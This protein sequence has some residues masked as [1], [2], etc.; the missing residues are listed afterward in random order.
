[1]RRNTSRGECSTSGWVECWRSENVRDE[2]SVRGNWF[3]LWVE[4][5]LPTGGNASFT[6]ELAVELIVWSFHL[7]KLLLLL[8]LL[9]L[10]QSSRQCQANWRFGAKASLAFFRFCSPFRLFFP[11]R[12]CLIITIDL[13][14]RAAEKSERISW[15]RLVW[16]WR[17]IHCLPS[18]HLTQHKKQPEE[19]RGKGPFNYWPYADGT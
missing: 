9:P 19:S 5:R 3:V 12:K 11:S 18:F 14:V 2:R 8:F 17:E 6:G 4:K 10:A 16:Y 15:G 13:Y 1:M 7:M